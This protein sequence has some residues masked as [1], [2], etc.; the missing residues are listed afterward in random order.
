MYDIKIV[1]GDMNA[2]VG[3]DVRIHD[4]GRHSLRR[5]K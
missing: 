1:M 4:V 2:N 5:V 3:K